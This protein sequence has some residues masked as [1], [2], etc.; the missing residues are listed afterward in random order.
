MKHVTKI[1]I[2]A[3]VATTMAAPA[4]TAVAAEVTLTAVTGLQRSNPLAKSFLDNYMAEVNKRGKGVVQI[5]YLGGQDVVPPR[6]A[7]AAL[8]RGQ[9]DMLHSPTAYYIGTVPEGY[10]M[11]ASNKLPSQIR[12]NGG[13]AA[14]QGVYRQKAGAQ[15]VAWGESQTSYN[16]YLM[17]R[18]K[19]DANGVP[20]LSGIKMRAT[21]TYRP[22]FRALGA[23]TINMKSSEI[24]TGIQ[25]GVVSGFGWPDV[26]IVSLGLHKLVKYRVDP[27]FYQ[28]N[29]V[30]TMNAAKW[31][32]LSDAAKK[33]LND[34]AEEYERTSV[35]YMER[36]R[37]KDDA[38]L[39]KQGV[40]ILQLEGDAA[41]KYLATAYSEIWKALAE[42]SEHAE[43]LRPLMYS[44]E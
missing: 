28:T 41:K 27:S 16:M 40:V 33:I 43:K 37:Q 6:K 5:R 7:A 10:G 25:R 1:A 30:V 17:D 32:G 34:V 8:K 21:G 23:S 2:A 31:D 14:L 39:K 11:L 29:T 12:K 22:L 20:D 18:P 35:Q 24:Y 9:F 36:E 13:F 42:R 44:P 3:A 38:E 26:G 4:A 15:L 19:L